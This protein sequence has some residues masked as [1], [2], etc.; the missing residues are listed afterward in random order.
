MLAKLKSKPVGV[1][2]YNSK[3][4]TKKC[5]RFFNSVSLA[6]AIDGSLLFMD[7]VTCIYAKVDVGVWLVNNLDYG[8]EFLSDSKFNKMYEII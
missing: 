1:L 4:D 3:K 8:I 2:Q 5:I 6:E 7:P